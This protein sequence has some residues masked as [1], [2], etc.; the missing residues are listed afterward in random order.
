MWAE[1][2]TEYLLTIW[3]TSRCVS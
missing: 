1:I 3:I 2:S